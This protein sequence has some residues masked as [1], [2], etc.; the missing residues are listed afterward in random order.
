[1]SR[2]SDYNIAPPIDR[3]AW[4]AAGNLQTIERRLSEEDTRPY[5]VDAWDAAL[6]ALLTLIKSAPIGY[7]SDRSLVVAYI[8]ALREKQA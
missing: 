4:R 2:H 3:I 1:M 7:E 6:D 5:I 8:E